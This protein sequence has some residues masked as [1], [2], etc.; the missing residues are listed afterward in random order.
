MKVTIQDIANMVGVSKSTVSRY[1]NG[2]YVSDDNKKKI[3]E[4]IEKTG[5]KSNFFAKRLKAKKSGLIGIIMPRIDSFT[6]GKILKSINKRLEENGYQGII[7][8]SELSKDKEIKHIKKLYQQ[9]VDGI[10]ILAVNITKEHIDLVK[11]LPIPILFTGQKSSLVNYIKVDDYK[12]GKALGQYIRD[13]GHRNIVF[14]GVTEEDKSVGVERKAGFCDAFKDIDCKISFVKTGFSFNE[15]YEASKEVIKYKP[16]AVIGATDNIVLG[17]I[18]Y[19]YEKGY[20]IPDEI[21]VAGFGGYDIGLAVH[22]TITTVEINY[23]ALG[24]KS[25][26]LI[27]SY[28]NGEEIEIDRNVPLKLIKRESVKSLL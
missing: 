12:A 15:A 3:E 7:L 18:R 13:N 23:E 21:S 10:I 25:S 1:L 17:F 14:L 9:G 20:S 5:F 26:D 6:S 19:A 8:T 27:L 28:I 22:P 16:T 11:K 24:E 2:G 4:A